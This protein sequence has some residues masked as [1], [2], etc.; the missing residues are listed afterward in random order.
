MTIPHGTPE[1]LEPDVP[2][3]NSWMISMATASPVLALTVGNRNAPPAALSDARV[4]EDR[5]ANHFPSTPLYLA[6]ILIAVS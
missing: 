3:S 6:S 4:L 2:G 1:S 5:S